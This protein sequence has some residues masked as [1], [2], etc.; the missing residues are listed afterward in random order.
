MLAYDYPLLNLFWSLIIFFAFFLWLWLLIMIFVDI[1]R[2]PDLSGAGKTL[3]L[4]FVLVI[5]LFGILG[6]LVVRGHKM[7]EHAVG[8]ARQQDEALQHYVREVA[9]PTSSS[10]EIERLAALRDRGAITQEEFEREKAKV[11]GSTTTPAR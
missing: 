1:F 11:L 6:Y 3:W 5:P 9:G 10:D 7:Q 4:L 8:A 2:S